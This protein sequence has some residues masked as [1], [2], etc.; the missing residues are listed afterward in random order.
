MT[1][2]NKKDGKILS[3]DE[4]KTK[5]ESLNETVDIDAAAE[6]VTDN[7]LEFDFENVHY[8]VRIPT[9][10]EKKEVNNYRNRRQLFL[11][12]ETDEKGNLINKTEEALI[13]IYAKQGVDIKAMDARIK[14]LQEE[15]KQANIILGEALKEKDNVVALENHRRDIV[16]LKEEIQVIIIQKTSLLEFSL[17]NQLTTDTYYYLTYLILEKKEEDEWK[18]IWDKHEDF[19]NAD[20]LLVNRATFYASCISQQGLLF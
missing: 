13:E 7:N 16:K 20:T 2:E 8:R 6:M 19:L 14:V 3:E 12:Q 10:G 4:A 18:R 5:L 15:I 9:F 17:E 11:L 1:E